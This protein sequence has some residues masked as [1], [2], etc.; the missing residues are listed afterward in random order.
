MFATLG[1]ARR[2]FALKEL[3]DDIS[4][5]KRAYEESYIDRKAE[6]PLISKEVYY[7]FMPPAKHTITMVHLV[8][9]SLPSLITACHCWSFI[10]ADRRRKRLVNSVNVATGVFCRC[11]M[12]DPKSKCSSEATCHPKVKPTQD[13]GITNL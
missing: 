11:H 7:D 6:N 13:R 8:P 3:I 4:V 12:I 9:S 2:D 1:A 10:L 5:L